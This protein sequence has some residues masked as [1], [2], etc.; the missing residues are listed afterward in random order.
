MTANEARQ[1]LCEHLR[2][3]LRDPHVMPCDLRR[4]A[5]GFAFRARGFGPGTLDTLRRLAAN[6]ARLYGH[7]LEVEL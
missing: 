4:T 7:S 3:T 5:S 6:S 2:R 1:T